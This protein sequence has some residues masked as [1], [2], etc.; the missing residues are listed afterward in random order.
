MS[1]YNC[2]VLEGLKK[3]DDN[4]INLVFTSPPY[5]KG[6]EYESYF[7]SY[8]EYIKWCDSWI[9]EIY[10]KL[11]DNGYFLLNIAND[12][13][14][15]IKAYEILNICLKYYKLCD[16]IIWF[17]YNRQPAN[18]KR[19]LTNQTEYI[20]LLRK[21]NNRININKENIINDYPNVFETKNI[22]NIWKIPF[23]T[24][25]KK[26][27]KKVLKGSKNNWGH[28]GFNNTLCEIVIKLF[29]NDNDIVLDC[30]AGMGQLGLSCKL[31]N[32]KYIG[33]EKD[34]DIYNILK[35]NLEIY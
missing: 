25:S 35:N 26:S 7:N 22:G 14:T 10:N 24:K 23:N 28:A 27:L 33:I 34:K 5:W 9:K 3:I 30:F 2:D 13:E 19:Q 31:L 6:F 32:R 15:T 21:H 12:S 18:T 17:V 1:I 4:T 16:T 8:Y 11:D 29:T 20:F